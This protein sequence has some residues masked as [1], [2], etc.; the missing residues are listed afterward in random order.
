MVLWRS[1]LETVSADAAAWTWQPY[2]GEQRALLLAAAALES[3][4]PEF[5]QV[6]HVTWYMQYGCALLASVPTV[7]HVH[8]R[9]VCLDEW[10]LS[11][12]SGPEGRTNTAQSGSDSP[13]TLHI[14]KVRTHEYPKLCELVKQLLTQVQMRAGKGRSAHTNKQGHQ[15]TPTMIDAVLRD[16]LKQL[17]AYSLDPDYKIEECCIPP[18]GGFTDV[19]LHTGGHRR[20]T[21]W[22]LVRSVIYTVLEDAGHLPLFWRSMAEL[23]LWITERTVALAQQQASQPMSLFNASISSAKQMLQ[24][25]VLESNALAEDEMVA[26]EARCVLAGLHLDQAVQSRADESAESNSLPLVSRADVPTRYP[27][28]Q[29]PAKTLPAHVLSSLEA[30]REL[31]SANLGWL[32]APPS[33]APSDWAALSKWLDHPRLQPTQVSLRNL[34]AALLVLRSVEAFVFRVAISEFDCAGVQAG[35]SVGQVVDKYRN[36]A[37]AFRTVKAATALSAVELDSLERLV[38]WVSFCV[39]HQAVKMVKPLLAEYGVALDPADTRHLV[40]SSKLAVDAALQVVAYLRKHSCP[41]RVV[42]SLR[43]GDVTIDFARQ[44]ARRDQDMQTAWATEQAAAQQ[45]QDAHWGRVT[46][47]QQELQV[48]D[49]ELQEKQQ[50][51]AEWMQRYNDT[52]EV[53][54]YSSRS[55]DEER[56]LAD[57]EHRRCCREVSD[58]NDKIANAEKP[59]AHVLQPLPANEEQALPVLFFLLMPEH[60]QVC[61]MFAHD[62]LSSPLARPHHPPHLVHQVLARLSFTAQ[63]LLLPRSDKVQHAN[64]WE[65]DTKFD[66]RVAIKTDGPETVWREYYMGG[67]SG[68]S[69]AAASPEVILGSDGKV[70]T[71]KEH[72]AP[73][74][75]RFFSSPRVGV[76]HPDR[77]LPRLFWAGGGREI[78]ARGGFYNPF[79]QV[80]NDVMVPVCTEKLS[81]GDQV[82]ASS[83]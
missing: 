12:H 62:C 46:R 59:P 51:Q 5:Q 43:S 72:W 69:H 18:T 61:S 53:S 41:S 74:N 29:V 78:D 56:L 27:R 54:K 50:E 76:W 4:A 36:V 66:T 57:R 23:K 58:L 32:P 42:F 71:N 3:A 7:G 63:L 75:V 55:N 28:L 21:A 60:F 17:L 80:P 24:T 9:L 22:P 47:K 40:L 68:R 15:M 39:V 2:G 6:P 14:G 25:T 13:A 82:R 44:V 33:C 64:K 67:S 19:G 45:R 31:A 37:S 48:L 10:S 77:L 16:A 73:S 8:L 20:N 26:I 79:A 1:F 70:V 30:R 49:S 34:A 65:P 83:S 52:E 81:D 11:V 35:V 38:V